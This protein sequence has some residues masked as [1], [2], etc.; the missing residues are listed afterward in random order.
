MINSTITVTDRTNTYMEVITMEDNRMELNRAIF[1]II[2]SDKPMK[3]MKDEVKMVRKAGYQIS[4]C[5]PH[6]WQVSNPSTRRWVSSSF[7]FRYR[8][9]LRIYNTFRKEYKINIEGCRNQ[10]DYMERCKIDFVGVLSK[11]IN[12]DWIWV[13][14]NRDNGTV[15]RRSPTQAKYDRL[16]S[17]RR[18][19]KW[20]ADEIINLQKQ[21]EKLQKN[22]IYYA[23]E[24]AKA[25]VELNKVRKELGLKNRR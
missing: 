9:V 25:E 24:K 18:S 19:V 13:L 10:S 7:E 14:N 15:Y 20:R 6:Q 1:T 21:I 2:T 3:E 22:L 17:A 4:K 8:E 23:G 12:N 16:L 11:P 5:A